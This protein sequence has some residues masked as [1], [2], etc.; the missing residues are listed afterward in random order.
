MVFQ[1]KIAIKCRS[2][3][4]FSAA[5]AAPALRKPWA[6]QCFS[7]MR[8]VVGCMF[9]PEVGVCVRRQQIEKTVTLQLNGNQHTY[10]EQPRL[11]LR[12]TLVQLPD[13]LSI[14]SLCVT[15]TLGR[16][17]VRRR[18]VARIG[19]RLKAVSGLVWRKISVRDST[20]WGCIGFGK[21][22]DCKACQRGEGARPGLPPC[23]K[24]GR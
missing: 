22:R 17:G 23:Y 20:P 24:P 4:P 14:T 18:Q 16:F 12:E 8:R 3:A 10:N 21:H 6:E 13:R 9:A 11:L 1:P 19:T 2:V 15:A 7:P 5:S